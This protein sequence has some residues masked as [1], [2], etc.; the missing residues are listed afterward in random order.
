MGWEA[1]V[2]Y[3]EDESDSLPVARASQAVALPGTGP[4]PY[5][6][7]AMLAKVAAD[8]DCNF[9]HPGYGFLS[10][11]AELARAC[12]EAGVSFVGPAPETLATFGDKAAARAL[13]TRTGLPCL[14][15]T[16][17]ATTLAEAESFLESLGE[18][19]AILIKALSG[20]GGRGMRVVRSLS[21][22]PRAWKRCGSE[23]RRAFGV[24]DLYVLSLIHI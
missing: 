21:E 14:E 3:T 20:G 22:L 10:E 8:H 6:D 16:A 1:V 13:A 17:A 12:A 19:G 24:E 7:A 5:L 18:G 15:G 4:E 11:S 2:V 9:F 23:A